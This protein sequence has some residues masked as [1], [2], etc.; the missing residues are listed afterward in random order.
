MV[1]KDEKRGEEG[2]WGSCE[3]RASTTAL[4]S[5]TSASSL[6]CASGVSLVTTIRV[7]IGGFRERVGHR[8]SPARDAG[9][10]AIGSGVGGG[11]ADFAE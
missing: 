2:K 5:P 6:V 7:V 3:W 10:G 8:A 9:E 4:V 11:P 1:E